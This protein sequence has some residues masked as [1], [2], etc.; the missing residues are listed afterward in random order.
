MQ[1][2][3]NLKKPEN[4]KVDLNLRDVAP[5][6]VNC[7]L[8]QSEIYE[9]A[10]AGIDLVMNKN[11]IIKLNQIGHSSKKIIKLITEYDQTQKIKMNK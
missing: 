9:I 5:I 8:R 6:I 10:E 11:I 4:L 1:K 3:Y 7:N 2:T